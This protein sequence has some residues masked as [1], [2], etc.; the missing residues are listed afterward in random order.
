M[1][2][3]RPQ[4][5]KMRV[6]RIIDHAKKDSPMMR[7][8]AI[9]RSE[10]LMVVQ[11]YHG[12]EWRTVWAL[13]RQAWYLTWHGWLGTLK[14]KVCDWVGWTKLYDI[15][16]TESYRAHTER[17]GRKC[18]GSPNCNNMHCIEDSVPKWFRWLTRWD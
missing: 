13:F 16:E 15:P 12:G 10:C 17:H 9:A 1:T 14:I 8:P 5:F 18:S 6:D 11:A 4:Q 2:P 3:K 7:I